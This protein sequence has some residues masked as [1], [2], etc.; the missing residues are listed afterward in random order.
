MEVSPSDVHVGDQDFKDI[1]TWTS[2]DIENQSTNTAAGNCRIIENGTRIPWNHPGNLVS[3]ETEVLV[4]K[5]CA[6]ILIPLLFLLG[7]PANVA[8]M[9]VFYKQ[10]LKERINVC[11][12][13]LALVDLLHLTPVF[14]FEVEQVYSWFSNEVRNGDIYRF[15]MNNNLLGFWG[16]SYGSMLLAAVVSTERCLCVLF[17]LTSQRCIPTK[18]FAVVVVFVVFTVSLLR[19]V[20]TAQ[21]RSACFYEVRTHRTSWQYELNSDYFTENQAMLRILEGVFFGLC[22]SVGCPVLVLITTVITAVRLRQIVRWRSCSSSGMST[23]KEIGVTRMLICLSV[24]FVVLSS[25]VIVVRVTRL[26]PSVLNTAYHVNLYRILVNCY[27]VC[28]YVSS[29]VN[30]VVYYMTGTKYRETLHALLG[31]RKVEKKT[32]DSKQTPSSIAGSTI[33]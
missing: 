3:W 23:P 19:F 26:F 9:V 14:V 24:E 5:I 27:S 29:S 1:P 22:L 28:F 20:V 16:F 8:N 2:R 10:G 6:G 11:L 13:T 12:F 17:P 31:I 30:F 4:Y 25:P 18:T 21:Y 7:M 32:G 33:L 15:V